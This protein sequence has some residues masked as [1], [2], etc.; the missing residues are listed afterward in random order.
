MDFSIESRENI[1]EINDILLE[2]K[3]VKLLFALFCN[4]QQNKDQILGHNFKEGVD[5]NQFVHL[6]E[7]LLAFPIWPKKPYSISF[8]HR[9]KTILFIFY[10]SI[11]SKYPKVDHK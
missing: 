8:V 2:Q 5:S 9:S 1:L 6:I 3:A 10:E 11:V 4:T 7:Y